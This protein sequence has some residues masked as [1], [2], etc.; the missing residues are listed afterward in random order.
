MGKKRNLSVFDAIQ[1]MESEDVK[2]ETKRRKRTNNE[3]LRAR[4]AQSQTKIYN[5]LVECRILLQRAMTSASEETTSDETVR[6]K[7]N[8]LLESLLDARQQLL[9]G[10]NSGEDTVSGN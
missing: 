7:C 6:G 9:L 4:A 3:S 5:H 1:E 10:G 8:T 2:A